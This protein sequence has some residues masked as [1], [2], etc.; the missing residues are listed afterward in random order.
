LKPGGKADSSLK[1][2]PRGDPIASG[3]AVAALALLAGL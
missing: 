3:L 2:R 1:K